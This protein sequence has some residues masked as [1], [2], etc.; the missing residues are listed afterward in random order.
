MFCVK[1]W[2]PFRQIFINLHLR[3]NIVSEILPEGDTSQG[4]D[5][6]TVLCRASAVTPSKS[7]LG[8]RQ[9]FTFVEC[10]IYQTIFGFTAAAA[11]RPVRLWLTYSNGAQTR[12]PVNSSFKRDAIFRHWSRDRSVLHTWPLTMSTHRQ[13]ADGP[14]ARLRLFDDTKSS[15]RSTTATVCRRNLIASTCYSRAFG[16]Q[17]SHYINN[18]KKLIIKTHA[19]AEEYGNV[20]RVTCL[21]LGRPSTL[22][23]RNSKTRKADRCKMLNYRLCL[24]DL[25]TRQ[26]SLR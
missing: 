16:R 13:M 8:M 3:C 1:Q 11:G 18:N 17:A 15:Y 7:Q 6:L 20:I 10:Q 26:K 12:I 4:W 22:N 9:R 5:F 19:I 25:A 14:S 2:I 24:R 21:S 23:R